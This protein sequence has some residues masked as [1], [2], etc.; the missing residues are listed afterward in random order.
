L[1]D[2]RGTG[3]G[4]PRGDSRGAIQQGDRSD[5]L[6]AVGELRKALPESPEALLELAQLTVQAGD[7]PRAGWQL[8]EAVRRFPER[9]DLR[10]ALARV[11]LVLGN[12]SQTREAVLA[13]AP[14][15]EQHAPALVLRAQ[16]ELQLGDLERALATLAE[17]SG[18]TRTGPRR[19]SRASR[20]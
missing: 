9:D 16:A 4:G 12:P 10:I 18:S 14:A 8:E 20:R 5:A 7:A 3:R 15:S 11:A 6:E 2:S 17:G 13:I 19:G 1:R